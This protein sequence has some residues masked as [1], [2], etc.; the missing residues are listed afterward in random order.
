[1][2]TQERTSWRTPWLASGLLLAVASVCTVLGFWQLDRAGQS[3]AIVERYEAARNQPPAAVPLDALAER[4]SLEGLRYRSIAV[5]GRYE[6]EP[7]FLI[8]NVVRN[9]SVGYYVLTPLRVEGQRHR[10]L[11]NRGWV[12][13]SADRR[14]LPEIDV[15]AE[16][17]RVVGRLDALP[18]P[19]LRLGDPVVGTDD[20]GKPEPVQVLSYPTIAELEG[21][22]GQPLADYQLLLDADQPHGFERDFPGPAAD[23]A[24]NLGYAG[25]WWLFAALAGIAALVV[26]R[27]ALKRRN[28]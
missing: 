27:R 2:T 10:L 15:P 20:T 23:P 14:V 25:Q 28:G 22:L 19:G 26:A 8:D 1:M 6:P 4:G 13:A 21:R 7:Q 24:R 18:A 5:E 17:R 3:R 16:P 11:V 12:Q 9:G